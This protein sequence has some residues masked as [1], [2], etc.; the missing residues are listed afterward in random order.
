M[1]TATQIFRLSHRDLR[2][3]ARAL[4]RLKQ[5]DRDGA[6]EY[7]NTVEV[8]FGAAS[9]IALHGNYPNP[10]NPATMIHYTLAE[11]T[12]VTLSVYDLHGKLIETLTD[13]VQG[14]GSYSVR[15]SANDLPS[16]IYYYELQTK[17]STHTRKMILGR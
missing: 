10:F 11:E 3:T 7:S 9:G 8:V 2:F 13:E 5:I 17:T 16:G 4:Y 6:Y 1:L 15:F 12:P 14:E